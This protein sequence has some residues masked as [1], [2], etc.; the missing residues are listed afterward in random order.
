L[1]VALDGLAR[2][3]DDLDAS[4][5]AASLIAFAGDPT[6]Q[7]SAGWIEASLTDDFQAIAAA[8]SRMRRR[9]AA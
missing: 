9:G 5:V 7:S 6:E 1:W 8:S 4:S 3:I 2:A